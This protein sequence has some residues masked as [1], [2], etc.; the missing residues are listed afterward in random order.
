MTSTSGQK[1]REREREMMKKKKDEQEMKC[2]CNLEL[3]SIDWIRSW[4]TKRHW[5][6]CDTVGVANAVP[7]WSI[8]IG[9]SLIS[10]D[11]QEL[12]DKQ[13]EDTRRKNTHT[14]VSEEE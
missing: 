2:H 9:E 11:L 7:N 14:Q 6:L 13:R 1:R 3:E 5:P 4:T 8:W 12:S 10:L